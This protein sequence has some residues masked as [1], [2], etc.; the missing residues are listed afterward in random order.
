[1]RVCIFVC[2]CVC[3][4]MHIFVALSVCSVCACVVSQLSEVVR[5]QPSNR[6]FVDSIPGVATLVL[7]LFPSLPTL[8]QSTQLYK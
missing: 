6:K 7:L 3:V 1:M 5:A 4:C 2:V 8:L